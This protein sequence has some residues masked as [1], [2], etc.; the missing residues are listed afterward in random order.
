MYQF[1]KIKRE[2]PDTI[3]LFRMGDFYE[4]FGDDAKIASQVLGI[5]LTA[6]NNRE[7]ASETPL[8]GFP[9]HAIDNYLPKLVKAG[10]RV[11]ICEQLE[12]P[13]FA[14]TIV[15]RGVT[16]IVTPGTLIEDSL[17]NHNTNNY[18]ASLFIQNENVGIAI[19]DV[20]TGEF[21]VGEI[22]LKELKQNLFN[23]SPSEIIVRKKDKE[24]ITKFSEN[25][26]VTTVEDW[27]FE[28]K[29]TTE[30][31]LEHFKTHS[32]KGFGI[33]DQK[34]GKIAAGVNL[35]Y[36]KETRK[37][38]LP[39]ISKISKLANQD[40]I[41]LDLATKRNLEL[42]ESNS[43]GKRKDTLFAVLNSTQTSMG[44]RL[45]VKWLNF[46]LKKVPQILERLEGVEDFFENDAL[47]LQTR[48]L[49]GQIADL[50][51]LISRLAVGKTSP[52]ELVTLK[53]SLQILPDLKRFL[54]NGK[55]NYLK[56]LNEN[57]TELPEI[58]EL[59]SKAIVPNPPANFREGKFINFGYDTKLDELKNFAEHSKEWLENFEKTE[60]ERSQIPSLKVEFNKVFGYYIIVT[61]THLEKVPENYQR[62]QTLV[63][64]E[65]F[66]TPELKDF[67]EKALSSE[68]KMISLEL[69]LFQK[70][71]TET[72]KFVSQI[73]LNAQC[74]AKIDVLSNF[75]EI[76]KNN[77]YTK[78][79]VNNS[80]KIRII[81]GRHPVVEKL[82]PTDQT[83]VKNDT[84]LDCE[85]SQI[86]I[87]TG[88][89]MAGKSTFLRQV[90]LIVLM[91]QV[92]SFVPCNFAE[93]GV[94]D[95]IFT[96]VGASDNITSGES[97]F[98]VEMNETANILNN[99]TTKSLILLDEIGRGTSTFD[100]LSIA[101]AIT[102]FLHNNKK[103]SART[104]F[105]THY[106]EL[107]DL[108]TMLKGVKNYNVEVKEIDGKVEFVRKIIRGGCDHSYGIQVAE[109]AGLP[110][111]VIKRAKTILKNLEANELN[112]ISRNSKEQTS[113][114]QLNLFMDSQEKVEKLE[115]LLE[116]LKAKV[117]EQEVENL[118][119]IQALTFLAE[120]QEEVRKGKF[121]RE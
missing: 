39:H 24:A 66:F 51:R 42:L 102:E 58:V 16:E 30:T 12:D 38:E 7:G 110:F 67:E 85:E 36:L 45:L 78:P 10:Y 48:I 82:L 119:P 83:F 55:S 27:I 74:L 112:L 71:C 89:N 47:R 22:E 64:A 14:K 17:L 76:A 69:E 3:L 61:K 100:G 57:L 11:S 94:V 77:S 2:N 117:M 93:I 114:S 92:G 96:R 60:K 95:K 31:L 52:R 13:K 86:W 109:M 21:S 118:T 1:N 65:R 103:V 104:L 40:L 20:S 111:N 116:T 87:I 115:L 108:E 113:L 120:I 68:E 63:N 5:T 90:G 46:P 62:K 84:F 32:L 79:I 23:L 88:P 99:A 70:I 97:T 43:F 29:F 72:V 8:A 15:K 34:L 59:L 41:L 37:T 91:A 106:H 80:D 101:W 6:R 50:E 81:A 75:A 53:N 54:Q 105:A 18:L 26:L 56:N 98:L 49:L 35:N 44:G 121:D 19:S 33:E 28:E 107:T 73:Q 9:Y 25:I 4:T